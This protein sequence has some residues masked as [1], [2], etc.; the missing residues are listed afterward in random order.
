[1]RL[2]W[3]LNKCIYYYCHVSSVK[4]HIMLNVFL[5]LRAL[6]YRHVLFSVITTSTFLNIYGIHSSAFPFWT[7]FE[8]AS[9]WQLY[10]IVSSLPFYPVFRY[11]IYIY[12]LQYILA[13]PSR[14]RGAWRNISHKFTSM[15]HKGGTIWQLENGQRP[16]LTGR[17]WP[18]SK[19]NEPYHQIKSIMWAKTATRSQ[20]C[21]RDNYW[22]QLGCRVLIRHCESFPLLQ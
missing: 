19:K 22:Q 5:R 7:S 12:W 20:S 2:S 13:V 15:T 11:N 1:M 21:V 8:M 4:I 14:K 3:S 16:T 6:Y 17:R 9:V 18:G 10:C